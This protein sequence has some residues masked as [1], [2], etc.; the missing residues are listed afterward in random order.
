VDVR[1]G[2]TTPFERMWAPHRSAYDPANAEYDGCPF[3]AI[4]SREGDES[5][6]VARGQTTYA[7]LN[8]HPYNPGHLMVLPY[9]H[10]ADL[11]ELTPAESV[12]LVH[13]T[14]QALRA[15]RTVGRPQSSNVG[16]NL[17]LAAGA[18]VAAHLHQHVVPRWTGDANFISVVGGVKVLSQL[19]EDT[20]DLVAE[21]WWTPQSSMPNRHSISEL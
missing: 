19:L 11:T 12:E 3:C 9:R 14:Q 17:G 8:R 13:M 6:V 20:R 7:V 5:L 21:A 16:L 2:G 4:P 18:S 1:S 10:V 15:L